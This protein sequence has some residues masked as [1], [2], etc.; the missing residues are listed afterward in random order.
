MS[1]PSMK[2]VIGRGC[3]FLWI[4]R[5][6]LLYKARRL[7]MITLHMIRARSMEFSW[8]ESVH[9]SQDQAKG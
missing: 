6:G 4:P 2:M 7:A 3:R 9:G 8:R 5:N 1:S